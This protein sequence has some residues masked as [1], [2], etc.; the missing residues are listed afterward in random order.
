MCRGGG[1]IRATVC[2]APPRAA[3]TAITAAPLGLAHRQ[4]PA[5]HGCG[6]CR[7]AWRWPPGASGGRMRWRRARPSRW[8]AQLRSAAAASAAPNASHQRGREQQWPTMRNLLRGLRCMR[9]LDAAARR[10]QMN[11]GSFFSLA[12][13]FQSNSWR[14]SLLPLS[15]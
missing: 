4:Q 9:L 15:P 11:Y 7:C 10:R 3:A 14:A 8:R 2:P 12:I 5:G 13:M 6:A 1:A